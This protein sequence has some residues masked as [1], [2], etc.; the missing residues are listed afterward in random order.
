MAGAGSRLGS[1]LPKPLV[2][3]GDRPMVQVAIECLDL[4]GPYV[5][6]IQQAHDQSHHLAGRLLDI[7]P[8]ASIVKVGGLTPGPAASVL[9]A[10]HLI[11]DSP[12][13]IAN[14]DQWVRWSPQG[15]V[16]SAGRFDGLIAVHRSADPRF[17]Y[18]E[19]SDGLVTRTA[20]KN[21][22]STLATCGIYWWRHGT[23]FIR[24][25][26][27]M[28]A[29]RETHCGELYVTPAYNHSIATGARIGVYEV[30]EMH[31]LGTVEGIR[32]HLG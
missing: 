1:D 4:P 15:F 23:E 11:D 19:A 5:F 31:D 25:A 26:A 30:D 22:I 3:V 20:E 18:V 13:L 6:V 21:P 24:A 7:V 2:P 8:D 14:C 29:T 12:L 32:E 17:S 16:E 27:Q 28:I 10:A 9:A